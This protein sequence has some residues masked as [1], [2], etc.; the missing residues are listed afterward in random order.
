MTIDELFSLVEKANVV[1][2]VTEL[3]NIRCSN[4][5]CP[6]EV[7]LDAPSGWGIEVVYAT[8]GVTG[9]P[10]TGHKIALDFIAAAD[11]LFPS[12]Y[13]ERMLKACKLSSTGFLK[14]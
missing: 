7:A 4:G 13:R 9:H 2:H 6:G 5:L 10:D 3:G 14:P 1:W 11:N 12:P 8:L